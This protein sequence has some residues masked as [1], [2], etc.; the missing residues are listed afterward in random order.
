MSKI[1][2]EQ[3]LKIIERL[4]EIFKFCN[5]QEKQAIKLY[6]AGL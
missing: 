1:K 2:K 4:E 6:L 3:M 5:E